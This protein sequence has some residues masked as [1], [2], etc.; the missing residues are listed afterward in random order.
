MTL[1][2]CAGLGFKRL[3]VRYCSSGG[4]SRAAQV[5]LKNARVAKVLFDG[6]LDVWPRDYPRK[7]SGT[8]T[9]SEASRLHSE[10]VR[11]SIRSPTMRWFI[12][13][14][15][16]SVDVRQ[17]IREEAPTLLRGRN[18]QPGLHYKGSSSITGGS[19]ALRSGE[20]DAPPQM[21]SWVNP[22]PGSK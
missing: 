21:R 19:P 15:E 3:Q 11:P 10:G 22:E 14:L 18:R 13:L 4:K 17:K 16:P 20:V 1:N 8:V 6:A 2:H 7:R 9:R 12:S 5:R